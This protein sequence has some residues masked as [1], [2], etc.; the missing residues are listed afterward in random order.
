MYR[1]SPNF[2][3]N[4]WV[5]EMRALLAAGRE[6]VGGPEQAAKYSICFWTQNEKYSNPC[7]PYLHR[8]I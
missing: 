7:S 1:Y 6:P 3:G 5:S 8:G 4:K 2:K